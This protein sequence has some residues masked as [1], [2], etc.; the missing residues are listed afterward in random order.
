MREAEKENSNK[1]TVL[2][3]AS[4]GVLSGLTL[5]LISQEDISNTFDVVGD[6]IQTGFAKIKEDS[7]MM[8]AKF[9]C[10][11]AEWCKDLTEKTNEA[12]EL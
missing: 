10:P 2:K 11:D 4:A 9:I 5:G 3:K 7:V 8:F 1:I 6:K 12:V